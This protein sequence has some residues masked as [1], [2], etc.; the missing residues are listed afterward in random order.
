MSI[1]PFWSRHLQAY[2]IPQYLTEIGPRLSDRLA[3]VHGTLT[4][5]D[6]FG[7][8]AYG[9]FCPMCLEDPS[10]GA[11]QIRIV[12]PPKGQQRFR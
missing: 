1:Y 10:A 9:C 12:N 6:P 7:I 5:T 4:N 11:R 2:I 3:I 8:G